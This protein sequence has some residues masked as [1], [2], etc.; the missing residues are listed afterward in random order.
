V[1]GYSVITSDECKLGHVVGTRGDY[2]VVEH[3]TLRK[4]KHLVPKTFAHADE[5]EQVVRLTISK[6]IVEESPKL[7]GGEPDE[8]AVAMH[9]GLAEGEPAPET[10]G[11]GDLL[12]DDP[13]E[14]AEDDARRAGI[15]TATE[16]R[17]DVQTGDDP[18]L[19]QG[20]TSPG[21]LGS[22]TPKG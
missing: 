21:L 13:A 16:E 15:P 6:E 8:R 12:P 20:T 14:T 3:G 18:A 19:E 2:V 1:E 7:N 9:Y 17:L 5:G 10:E 11:Y 22:R 4:S